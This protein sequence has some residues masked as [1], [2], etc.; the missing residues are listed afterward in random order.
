MTMKS[1]IEY[2]VEMGVKEAYCNYF[3]KEYWD[4]DHCLDSFIS[5]FQSSFDV[6]DYLIEEFMELHEIKPE[7]LWALDEEHVVQMLLIHDYIL[8]EVD[9]TWYLFHRNI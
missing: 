6:D 4:E 7:L 5:T 1:E 9:K 2:L 3:G 8:E